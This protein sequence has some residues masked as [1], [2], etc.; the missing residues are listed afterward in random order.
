MTE[1][2]LPATAADAAPEFTNADTAKAWLENVPLANVAAAQQQLLAQL[3]EVN[4]FEAPPAARL[5][6]L[7]A[8]REAVHF[9][10]IEQARLLTLKAAW[11]MDTVGLRGAQTEISAIKVV[12][13]RTATNVIDRAIQVHGSLGYTT[14]LPLESMYRHARYGRI[15]DGPD[16]VPR[17]RTNLAW[18]AAE[19]VAAEIGIEPDVRLHIDKRIP[20]AGGMAGGSAGSPS[21]V[22]SKSVFRN[23][24]STDVGI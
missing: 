23:F 12:A 21:P 20:V 2:D 11:L 1:F 22:G 7:E 8:V 4:R 3:R 17:D 16:E 10:E 24:T 9:V 14:D 18:R 15:V 6:T 5:A 13:A 19:L